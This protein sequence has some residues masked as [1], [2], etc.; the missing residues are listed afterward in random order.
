MIV[1]PSLNATD[2]R[3]FRSVV[4][5]SCKAMLC[6]VRKSCG[7]KV[8]HR[9]TRSVEPAKEMCDLTYHVCHVEL[10]Q[11]SVRYNDLYTL[12]LVSGCRS[13]VNP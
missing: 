2:F 10:S 3:G 11:I 7:G 4:G 1:V 5:A 9:P 6:H 12:L 13:V 8:G